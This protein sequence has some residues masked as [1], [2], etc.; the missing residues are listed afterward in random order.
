MA[1]TPAGSI[2][3]TALKEWHVDF[4]EIMDGVLRGFEVVGCGFSSGS[5]AES[6]A[7]SP[8]LTPKVV[9]SVS[10]STRS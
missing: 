8:S 7:P 6:P 10:T 5:S 2:T 9:P 4:K 3:E 1:R